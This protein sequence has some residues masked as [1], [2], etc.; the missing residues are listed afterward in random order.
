MCESWR[1]QHEELIDVRLCRVPRGFSRFFGLHLSLMASK[2][3]VDRLACVDFRTLRLCFGSHWAGVMAYLY[4]L[5]LAGCP[6]SWLACVHTDRVSITWSVESNWRSNPPC[7]A[8]AEDQSI[9][10]WPLS[11][12]RYSA[13]ACAINPVSFTRPRCGP[14][15]LED[16]PC[17]SE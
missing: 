1:R 15:S 2:C 11:L 14:S 3:F 17:L 10:L 9:L 6:T 4:I 5:G 7:S 13:A 16:I 8:A 12:R